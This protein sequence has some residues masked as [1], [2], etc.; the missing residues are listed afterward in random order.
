MLTQIKKDLAQLRDPDRAKNLSWFFKTAKG[1]YGEGDIFLGILVPEQRKVA[2]K[3]IDLSLNDLQELLNSKIHEYRFTALLILISKYRKAGELVKE[4]IFHLILKNTENINN[5]DLVDLSAPRIIG[6]FL[7]NRERSILY[8]LAKSKS[9]WERRISIL[10]TFTFIGNNDFEDAL[11]ISELLLHD[12][13]DLIHKAVGWALREIG[14][15]D[16]NLEER[17]LNK[18][19]FRMPRTMLRYAIEKFDEEKRQ[20]Y[21]NKNTI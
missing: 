14:K 16:Q 19:Y 12:E 17:F 18:H 15:R 13:H 4:E 6:D 10:S 21:L 7:L 2:K 11:N 1:Q 20:K 9:L 8:K 3:H 5:W